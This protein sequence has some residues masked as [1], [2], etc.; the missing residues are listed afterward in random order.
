MPVTI[1][2]IEV[3]SF[4]TELTKIVSAD[5]ILTKIVAADVELIKVVAMATYAELE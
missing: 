3:A 2:Y 5:V 1:P 4:D